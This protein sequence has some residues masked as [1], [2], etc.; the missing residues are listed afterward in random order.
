MLTLYDKYT[1]PLV[2]LLA[3]NK[4]LKS[5]VIAVHKLS[6]KT[7]F[8]L[9]NGGINRITISSDLLATS[10][11][12]NGHK[13]TTI[14]E[15]QI[16]PSTSS[17]INPMEIHNSFDWKNE[18]FFFTMAIHEQQQQ[19]ETP[20]SD[21]LLPTDDLQIPDYLYDTLPNAITSFHCNNGLL[22]KCFDLVSIY[23]PTQSGSKHVVSMPGDTRFRERVGEVC[24]DLD[25]LSETSD[26][27]LI[28]VK[29]HFAV[30]LSQQPSQQMHS[31]TNFAVLDDRGVMLTSSMK[32][33]LQPTHFIQ[34]QNINTTQLF[35]NNHFHFLDITETKQDFPNSKYMAI[36]QY[37]N[38]LGTVNGQYYG[39]LMLIP[40]NIF[41][42]R[43]LVREK[44][45]ALPP[46]EVVINHT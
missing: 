10:Q 42:T 18:Y 28:E 7:I 25:I 17:Q 11:Y 24:L 37:A 38:H 41:G 22:S 29:K 4:L 45:S 2:D 8:P 5:D 27:W 13:T 35:S 30:K 44:F 21:V 26:Q 40:L 6:N 1:Q 39:K 19:T 15:L 20:P 3:I 9:F 36:H 12:I 43:E 46:D 31:K 16:G 33:T 14:G 32:S 34:Q 23:S